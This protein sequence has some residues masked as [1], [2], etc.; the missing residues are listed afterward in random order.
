MENARD[1]LRD[2]ENHRVKLEENVARLKAAMRHW[3]TWELEYE[4]MKEEVLGLPE[5]QDLAELVGA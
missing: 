1:S 5:K 3:Q 4:E 2:L